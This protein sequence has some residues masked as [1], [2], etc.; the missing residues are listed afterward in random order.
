MIYK[1]MFSS[2]ANKGFPR[3]AGGAWN[4][5]R[6]GGARRAGAP[7]RGVASGEARCTPWVRARRFASQSTAGGARGSAARTRVASATNP[8]GAAKSADPSVRSPASAR[9]HRTFAVRDGPRAAPPRRRAMTGD[10]ASSDAARLL[11]AFITTFWALF[12][13][14]SLAADLGV[15]PRAVERVVFAFAAR[16]KSAS[17]DMSA[18]ARAAWTVPHAWFAH[19]YV[20]AALWTGVVLARALALDPGGALALALFH[21]HVLRRL[22]EFALVHRPRR[23]SRMHVVGYL[24]GLAYYLLAPLTLAPEATR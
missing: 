7:G 18:S 6:R 16:G 11:A 12:A 23:G 3:E 5:P 24:V 9:R 2:I 8:P 14:S 4:A 10:D 13:G 21:A 22:L 1:T 19:F 15:L 17:S 20:L